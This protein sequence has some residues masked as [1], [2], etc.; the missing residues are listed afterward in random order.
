MATLGVLSSKCMLCDR[1]L[2]LPLSDADIGSNKCWYCGG[3]TQLIQQCPKRE[4]GCEWIGHLYELEQHKKECEFADV[5]C[6]KCSW[7]GQRRGLS[8]HENKECPRRPYRCTYCRDQV[9]YEEVRTRH[10]PNCRDYPEPMKEKDQE[11]DSLAQL[12]RLP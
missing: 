5:E 4:K 9:P 11:F 8:V 6:T 2:S 10:W 1:D 7:S 12:Q 3:Q